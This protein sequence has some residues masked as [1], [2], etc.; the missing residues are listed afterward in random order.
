M[1]QFTRGDKSQVSDVAY[2]S[3]KKMTRL[4]M[5]EA[6]PSFYLATM[7]LRRIRLVHTRGSQRRSSYR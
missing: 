1:S 7:S 6:A 4:C 2:K 5:L 3:L